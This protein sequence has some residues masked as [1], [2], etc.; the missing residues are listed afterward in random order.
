MSLVAP[1]PGPFRVWVEVPDTVPQQVDAVAVLPV[2]EVEPI[3]YC[4]PPPFTSM[5]VLAATD[6]FTAWEDWKAR[7]ALEAPALTAFPTEV[8]TALAP[9]VACCTFS[10]CPAITSPSC[11]WSFR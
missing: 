6:P 3:R 1:T 8:V 5:L 11:I 7:S 9:V 2:A 4:D 10:V